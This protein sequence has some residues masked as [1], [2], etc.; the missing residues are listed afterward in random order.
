MNVENLIILLLCIV[1]ASVAQAA[2]TSAYTKNLKIFNSKGITGFQAASNFLHNNG[3]YDVEIIAINGV[4][5]DHYDPSKKQLSLSKDVYFGNSISSVA[6][7]CHEVGHAIQDYEKYKALRFRNSM[8][9]ITRISSGLSWILIFAGIIFGILDLLYVGLI[10]FGIVAFF[11]LV[12]LPV[13][14][15]AS[16]RAIKY[17]E[18]DVLD[19]EEL[20]GARHVLN[21]AALTYVAALITSLLQI[22]RFLMI[23]GGRSSRR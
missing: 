1:I 16:N 13:E 22:A 15:N 11:Q 14:F 20:K 10:M 17:L 5:S 6:I 4:L 2:V 19:Y 12:T 8:V 3:I 23:F 21:A 18:S 9:P 7:A